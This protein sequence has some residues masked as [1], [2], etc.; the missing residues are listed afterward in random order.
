MQRKPVKTG[1]CFFANSLKME[2]DRAMSQYKRQNCLQVK[3]PACAIFP[4]HK[5]DAPVFG[6]MKCCVAA[7]LLR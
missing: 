6:D 7:S 5:P 4:L 1:F 3:V 2:N